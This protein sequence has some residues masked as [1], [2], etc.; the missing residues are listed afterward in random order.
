MYSVSSA[1]P[2]KRI[3]VG[4][5]ANTIN[6]KCR[7]ATQEIVGKIEKSQSRLRVASSLWLLQVHC[8]GQA[9]ARDHA[10]PKTFGPQKSSCHLC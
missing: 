5:S 1:F 4:F 9:L 8:S 7:L 10:E 6:K 2:S 3:A